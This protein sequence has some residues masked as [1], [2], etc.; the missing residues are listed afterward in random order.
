[1]MTKAL[2]IMMLLAGVARA[3]DEPWAKGVSID[4]Q[5]IANALFAEGNQLFAQQAHGPALEKYRQ[6]IALWDH[7]LIR[8]NMAVTEIRLDHMLEA[9]DDLDRALRFGAAPFS[10][11][12]YRQAQD[13]QALV[14]KQITVIE[15]KCDQTDVHVLFDGK[16]WFNCPGTQKQRVLAGE[17]IL[18]GERDGYMTQTR[19]LV[20]VGGG[21]K[22]EQIRLVPIDAGVKVAYAYSRTI[23]WTL[24]GS[25]AAVAL[26]GLGVW[27]WGRSQMDKFQNT[28]SQRCPAGCLA[29]LSDQPDLRSEH[30]A[31]V[32]KGKIGTSMMIGGGVATLTGL[33]LVYFDK[34]HRVF[35][36]VEVMPN[37]SASAGVSWKW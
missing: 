8:F 33:L 24:A 6:A 21:T 34:P 36:N 18:L 23:P 5:R 9:A 26:G 4:K 2:V 37:G 19:R 27:L 30:D 32:L 7:P 28:F 16:P 25:G 22:Q 3:D 10:A 35:P 15:A 17:H 11:D 13:Y 12:L 1:M 14:K 20:L 31:A 29:D